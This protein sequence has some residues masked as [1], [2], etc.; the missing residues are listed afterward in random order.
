M[1]TDE[2]RIINPEIMAWYSIIRFFFKLKGRDRDYVCTFR[3]T[4][5]M[6]TTFAINESIAIFKPIADR[7]KNVVLEFV[8]G[9]RDSEGTFVFGFNVLLDNCDESQ[10]VLE[11]KLVEVFRKTERIQTVVVDDIHLLTDDV[12]EY[13]SPFYVEDFRLLYFTMPA[14]TPKEICDKVFNQFLNIVWNTQRKDGSR[15]YSLPYTAV[16]NHGVGVDEVT[17]LAINIPNVRLRS[18]VFGVVTKNFEEDVLLLM[19][20]VR[21]ASNS[22]NE[23]TMLLTDTKEAYVRIDVIDPKE[24]DPYH[25]AYSRAVSLRHHGAIGLLLGAATVNRPTRFNEDIVYTS[26]NGGYLPSGHEQFHLRI[27]PYLSGYSKDTLDDFNVYLKE[28]IAIA[29]NLDILISCHGEAEAR[30]RLHANTPVNLRGQLFMDFEEG[31]VCKTL[32]YPVWISGGLKDLNIQSISEYLVQRLEEIKPPHWD[33]ILFS[34][35]VETVTYETING[36][37]DYCYT[38]SIIVVAH[39]YHYKLVQK[40]LR[41]YFRSFQ[42][43]YDGVSG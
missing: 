26:L 5:P 15:P 4:N 27:Q 20:A 11:D 30:K 21:F 35:G 31:F 29:E 9:Y 6:A 43:L 23:N 36:I 19:E 41:E 22:A 40:L 3:L 28:V 16:N 1:S 12:K 42:E 25:I 34:V 39:R 32:S 10:D 13:Y 38:V 33:K 14:D 8:Q 18:I 7:K 37:D 24:D 2:I 17:N